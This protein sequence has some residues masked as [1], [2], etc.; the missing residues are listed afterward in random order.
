MRLRDYF[1]KRAEAKA[2]DDVRAVR[3]DG[4]GEK[5][6]DGRPFEMTIG[7][8]LLKRELSGIHTECIE[9]FPSHI[10]PQPDEVDC[11]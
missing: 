11:L 9:T 2:A 6:I 7:K 10:F 3:C 8:G 4:C 5:L 1:K